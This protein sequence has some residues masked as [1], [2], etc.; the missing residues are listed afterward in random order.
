MVTYDMASYR[1]LAPHTE[2]QD[3]PLLSGCLLSSFPALKQCQ[4]PLIIDL[5]VPIILE[6][7]EV[8]GN[9]SVA[10]QMVV[11]RNREAARQ[12]NALSWGTDSLGLTDR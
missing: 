5:W 7:L 2:G 3:A 8:H 11:H 4:A 9:R 12:C 10:A 6:N 1:S